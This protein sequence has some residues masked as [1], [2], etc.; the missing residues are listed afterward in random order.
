LALVLP[1]KK[2]NSQSR[3]AGRKNI[4][5]CK[6]LT[7]QGEKFNIQGAKRREVVP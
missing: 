1:H 6:L 3:E 4:F 2:G 7:S 5:G